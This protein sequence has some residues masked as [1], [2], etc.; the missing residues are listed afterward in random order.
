MPLDSVQ[1]ILKI[2]DTD[3]KLLI[4]KPFPNREAA[5][6]WYKGR[7]VI[8]VDTPPNKYEIVALPPRI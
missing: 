7:T 1:V 4:A 5:K 3:G 6:K 2:Y 8:I